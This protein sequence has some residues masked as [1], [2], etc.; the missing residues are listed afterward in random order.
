MPELCTSLEAHY[1][2]SF[3][4]DVNDDLKEIPPK[5]FGLDFFA[6]VVALLVLTGL[7]ILSY[8]V[9]LCDTWVVHKWNN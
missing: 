3:T 2:F 9:I 7:F 4:T 6:V 5:S 8:F 1:D